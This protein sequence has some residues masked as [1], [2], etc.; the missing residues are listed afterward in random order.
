MDQRQV[1]KTSIAERLGK[2]RNPRLRFAHPRVQWSDLIRSWQ[3]WVRLFVAVVL[4]TV[5]TFTNRQFLGWG[6]L[7]VFAIMVVPLGRARSFLIAF[8]PYASLW[9]VFTFLRSFADE[10]ILAETMNTK[11]SHL[12]RWIFGGELPTVELQS[13]FYNP[14]HQHWWDYYFVFVHW[15]YFLVPH[16]VMA[17][18]WWKHPYLFRRAFLTLALVLTAGLIFYFLIP[19]NPPWMAPETVN[20]PASATAYRIMGPIAQQLGGGLYQAGYKVVGESNPIAA[21]PSI[22]FAVTF[23]LFWIARARNR[24]TMLIAGFYSLSM[25]IGL[26]YLGEHYVVDVTA[27]GI[28]TAASWYIAGAWLARMWGIYNEEAMKASTP[29]PVPAHRPQEHA[30]D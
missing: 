28:I 2:L 27:G 15:S 30:A 16:V 24:T 29:G 9:F 12:E 22:H 13:R 20:T 5:S 4:I 25:G 21:M 19:S 10:T 11:V 1:H 3:F 6:L 26:V 8:I 7:A 23:I 14:Y 17:W 18:L